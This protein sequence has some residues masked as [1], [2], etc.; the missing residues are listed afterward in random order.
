[1][2]TLNLEGEM[3]EAELKTW[4]DEIE[5]R[6]PREEFQVARSVTPAA[7]QFIADAESAMRSAFPHGHTLLA[8]WSKAHDDAFN[9]KHA[10]GDRMTAWTRLVGIFDAAHRQVLR[11]G[12]RA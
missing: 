4:F 9:V 5:K 3:T 12:R 8:Q 2:P 11:Q 1:M 7:V 6:L 10:V